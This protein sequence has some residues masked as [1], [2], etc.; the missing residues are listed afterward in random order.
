MGSDEHSKIDF[1]TIKKKLSRKHKK[2]SKNCIA[3]VHLKIFFF[4]LKNTQKKYDLIYIDGS[5]HYDDVIRDANNS[6][7]ALNKNGIIIF[8]DFLKG[9]TKNYQKDPILAILNFIYP[10]QKK[11]K[12]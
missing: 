10:E 11:H 9:I 2:I 12:N 6:F 1:T 8:D 7:N 5:H 3:R 4:N